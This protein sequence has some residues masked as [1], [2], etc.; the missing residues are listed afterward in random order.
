CSCGGRAAAIWARTSS[1][2]GTAVAH[3]AL[4]GA[5]ERTCERLG[6]VV[7]AVLGD[8]LRRDHA[9]SQVREPPAVELDGDVVGAYRPAG[10]HDAVDD[11]RAEVLVQAR[12]L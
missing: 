3:P 11:A 9:H 5:H 12:H 1:A 10:H 8:D 7:V 4:C 2:N 6:V